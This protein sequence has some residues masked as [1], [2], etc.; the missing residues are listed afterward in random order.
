MSTYIFYTLEGYTENL[1]DEE[2]SNYQLLGEADGE[3]IKDALSN[4]LNE[5]PWIESCG[6]KVG[7]GDI[8]TRK[9]ADTKRYLL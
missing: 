9:L 4:L 3:T 1:N 6:F 2:V 5:S 7:T 8:I